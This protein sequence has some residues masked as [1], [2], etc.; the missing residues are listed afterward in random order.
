MRSDAARRTWRVVVLLVAFTLP[1]DAARPRIAVVLSSAVGPFVAASD[2]LLIRL[3]RSPV[4][5]E[6]LLFDLEGSDG[7]A[8]KVLEDIRAENPAAIVTIGT[9]AT[10]VVLHERWDAPIVYSMV[11]YPESSGIVAGPGRALTG[12]SLDVPLATQFETL[13]TLLPKAKRVGVVYDPSQTG[14]VVAMAPA[15]ARRQGFELQAVA[16]EN[17]SDA[18]RAVER[19]LADVDVLWSV[20]DGTVFTADTSSA[21]ILAALQ[22]R[23]PLFGL[24]DAHV[25]SGALAALS[26][27]YGDIGAQ[28]AELVLRVLGGAAARDVPRTAPRKAA[29]HLNLRTARHIGVDVPDALV[30]GAVSVIQ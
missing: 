19:L 26:C 24:S 25:R 21:I 12:A 29:L 6:L 2:V 28:T 11:L 16:V 14:Q 18:M 1:A 15:A 10:R 9:L 30:E 3:D 23:V 17:P 22:A 13:R 20:A 27:D 8:P 7:D 5:P 4:Q